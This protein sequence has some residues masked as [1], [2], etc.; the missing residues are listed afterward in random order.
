MSLRTLFG[1]DVLSETHIMKSLKRPIICILLVFA[2]LFSFCA[3]GS[4]SNTNNV[5]ANNAADDHT[6][7]F[8][9][10]MELL[11]ATGF[12]VDYYEDGYKLVTVKDGPDVYLVIPQGAD[13]K[14]TDRLVK[15]LGQKVIKLQLK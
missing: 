15:S 2:V 9:R 3:C 11:Y 4:G 8:V 12:S 5:P 10:S 13:S 14:T 1:P 6:P 7:A